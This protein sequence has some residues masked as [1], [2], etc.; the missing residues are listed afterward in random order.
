MPFHIER[1]D[2]TI[3]CIVS[4]FSSR[5]CTFPLYEVLPHVAVKA[6]LLGFNSPMFPCYCAPAA[7]HCREDLKHRTFGSFLTA[8][9]PFRVSPYFDNCQVSVPLFPV[10]NQI[11]SAEALAYLD[12]Y[13]A[14][15]QNGAFRINVYSLGQPGLVL[16]PVPQGSLIGF[17]LDEEI[18]PF[19][20]ICRDNVS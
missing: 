1:I 5:S 12:L 19:S 11:L 13:P 10:G 9:L 7:L 16:N 14:M 20:R 2:N 8:R 17:Q 15:F 4:R 6:P 18:P 3:L